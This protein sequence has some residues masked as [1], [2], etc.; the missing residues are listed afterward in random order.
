MKS[1]CGFLPSIFSLGGKMGKIKEFLVSKN[2][3]EFLRYVI[4][5]G[6]SALIDMGALYLLTEYVFDGRKDGL[7]LTLSVAGGFI[8]GLIANYLLSQLFVF[9]SDTQREKGKK[10]GAFLIYALV[11]LVGFG[12]TEGLMHLGMIFVSHEGLW[13]ILLNC[14]VKGVVLIWIYLGRK[15]FVYK[16]E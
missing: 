12:L 3:F 1:A 16:G 2:L 14:F 5:G 13:Y 6:I 15:I 11:G 10:A 9:T 8:V 7:P 4:V